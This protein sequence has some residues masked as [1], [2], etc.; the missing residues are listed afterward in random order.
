MSVQARNSSRR[1]KADQEWKRLRLRT[2]REAVDNAADCAVHSYGEVQ[3]FFLAHP[4]RSLDRTLLTLADPDG[5]TFVLSISWVRTRSRS[6]TADL[7]RLIDTDGT[8]SIA[9]LAF[10]AL[11]ARGV[12]FTGTPFQSRRSGDT[13]V[14]AEAATVSGTP[15]ASLMEGSVAAASRL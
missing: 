4:C 15:G 5:G 12:R 14:V 1:A 8:G 10:S 6:D 11:K 7:Q 13:L 3:R 9:P 2:V